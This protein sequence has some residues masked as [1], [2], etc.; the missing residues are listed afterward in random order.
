[1]EG[2]PVGRSRGRARG[3][4]GADKPPKAGQSAF[5][6][7]AAGGPPQPAAL[8]PESAPASQAGIQVSVGRSV[9]APAPFPVPYREGERPGGPRT[10]PPVELPLP[11]PAGDAG[12]SM[13]RG[14]LR[15]RR[16]INAE[17][18]NTRPQHVATSKKGTSGTP[19]ALMAN[20]YKVLE[21]PD[22][23]LYQY[24]VDFEPEEDRTATRK[25]LLRQHRQLL[26]SYIFD[27]TVLYTS[28][29]FTTPGENKVFFSRRTT[30]DENIRITLR[31]VGDMGRGDPHYLQFYNILT[32]KCLESL[33][34][35]LVGRNYFDANAK[36]EI[37][38]YQFELWPGYLTSIRQH[39]TDILMC[40]EINHKIMR[41]ET[42]LHILQRV[43]EERPHDYQ[44]AFKAEVIGLTVLTSYNNNTYRIDDVDYNQS[45]QGTFHSKKDN[46]DIRYMDYYMNRYGIPIKVP[47][48]PLIVTRSTARDRRAG[49]DDIIYLVPE[50]CRATGLTDKMRNDFRL[51]SA[52]AQHTR[53]TPDKRIDKLLAFN[54]R[55]NSSTEIKDEFTNWNL[56]LD[57]Q[58]VKVQ[59]RLLAREKIYFGDDSLVDAGPDGDWTKAI[60]DNSLY[61]TTQLRQWVVVVPERIARDAKSFVAA[62]VRSTK[63]FVISEPQYLEIRN[64]RSDSYTDCLEKCMSK[65]NPQLVMCILM[66][67]RADTYSAIK[68]KLCIDR[69]VPSQVVTARCFNPKGMMSIATKVA[70]QVNCKIGGIPWTVHV[71]LNGL[72]VVGYDACHDTNKR[73]TDFGAMVASLDKKLSRY[74]SAVS[75]HT[76]GEELSSHLATNMVKALDKYKEVNKGSL[77]SHIIIY[78]DGVGEGQIPF[79]VDHEVVNVQEAIAKFYGSLQAVKLGYILVTKRI[80]TRFFLGTRNPLPGTVVDDVVT[81]PMKYDF[82]LISQG[83]KQGTVAPTSYSVIY[84]TLSLNPD[85]IQLLTYKMT[86]MYFNCSTTMRLPAPVQF[87][88]KL[89]FLVSQSI[90]TAPTNQ[91]LESLLYFL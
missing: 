42:L 34:L 4:P 71:P 16:I 12:A 81:N 32:R 61:M 75:A 3:V 37:R 40:A 15:G 66:K 20:Y 47:T 41:Q 54:R 13:G 91:H 18:L 62:M 67:N 48:Q 58:L 28:N 49:K 11:G 56:K 68:K 44:N 73:G 14:A 35:Q 5:G 33:N 80:N 27:G 89:A 36:V 76:S 52:L 10:L 86:H 82:F 26:G 57:T 8:P 88:H 70:I 85:K 2:K 65:V 7:P 24:R 74:F 90:H 22:W 25:G 38:E 30:D 21:K 9:R 63:N 72:M 31:L 55:L 23:C 43:K 19:V 64:D 59:G 17:I 53:V 39:E 6:R 79:V 51:M 77:P 29:R 45:P 83:V 87:A 50:L 1:M 84:D 60:R 46:K 78:R 69:P